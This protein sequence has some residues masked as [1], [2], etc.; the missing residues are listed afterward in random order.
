[1]DLTEDP[2]IEVFELG[3]E[4]AD[5]EGFSWIVA[6]GL[7]LPIM[8]ENLAFSLPMKESWRCYTAVLPAENRVVAAG[9]MLIAGGIAQLSAGFAEAYVSRNW[10]RPALRP[11]AAPA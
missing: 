1:M 2:G 11:S 7:E 5:G 3:E 8:A 10:Q 9:A 4:E 6:Q